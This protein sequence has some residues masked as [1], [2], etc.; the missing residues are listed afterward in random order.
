MCW[1]PESQ[2]TWPASGVLNWPPPLTE[3]GVYGFECLCFLQVTP[4]SQELPEPL[5]PLW[6]GG[7][8]NETGEPD[9]IILGNTVKNRD[10]C[11]IAEEDPLGIHSY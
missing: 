8:S 5:F 7:A 4:F 3:S 9:L 2:G 11:S 1:T 10:R 6:E